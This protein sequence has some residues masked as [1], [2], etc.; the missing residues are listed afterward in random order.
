MNAH[1]HVLLVYSFILYRQYRSNDEIIQTS[2]LIR[3]GQ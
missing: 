3:V 1:A 2:C